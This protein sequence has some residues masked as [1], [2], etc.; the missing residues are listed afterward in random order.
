MWK[1]D[2]F[3]W[4]EYSKL[5]EFFKDNSLINDL[6]V[7]EWD[8]SILKKVEKL[9]DDELQNYLNSCNEKLNNADSTANEIKEASEWKEAV[10]LEI[11]KRK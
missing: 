5:N 1:P 2:K 10:E 7:D 11:K 9:L 3:S 8:D 4:P 6:D